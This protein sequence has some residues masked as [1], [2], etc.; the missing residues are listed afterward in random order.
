VVLASLTLYY[1]QA[2]NS[3]NP[4]AKG[5]DSAGIYA[6][7]NRSVVTI[8]GVNLQITDT[9]SG[10]VVSPVS[11]YA[12]GFVIQ[13]S[14]SYYLVTNFHVVDALINTT[15]TF[16]NGDAYRGKV[17][18]TDAYSDL[19]VVSTQANAQ[20]FYP[21]KF[22]SSS[23]LR[24]GDPVVAIGNPLG[25]AGTITYGIVSQLGRTIQYQSG[26]GGYPIANAIQFSA[27]VNPGNSGG[28]LLNADGNVVGITTAGIIGAE[29][30][31]FAISSDTI[32]RELPSLITSGS[33]DKHSYLGVRVEDM[34]YELSQL[35]GTNVTYGVLVASTV[36]GGPANNAG[37]RGGAKQV[38]IG[39]QNY[40][41]GGDVIVSID[42][43]RIV[44]YD[45]FAT[46]LERNTLPGQTIQI[47]IIRA[48]NFMT[49]DVTLGARPPIA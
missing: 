39:G 37:L 10:P 43:N 36:P 35:V 12:S 44:N 29:G 2:V 8:Q 46:Y 11:V 22:A 15:V 23:S 26:S 27:P 19:A 5:L 9:S 49:I 6:K 33:Y 41:V 13:Y 7:S 28:P 38:V 3:G 40:T 34:N 32:I 21:L 31:G 18:G 24:V 1:N 47:G 25:F 4:G 45:A 14:N 48:G 30:L 16:S 17:V 42:G 20:E